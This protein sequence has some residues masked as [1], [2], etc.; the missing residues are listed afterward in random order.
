VQLKAKEAGPKAAP[1]NFMARKYK[2]VGELVG[3]TRLMF[4][5]ILAII[6]W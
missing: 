1:G 2:G 6:I 4:H 5:A 3:H